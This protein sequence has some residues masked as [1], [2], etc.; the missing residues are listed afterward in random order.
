MAA[1]H[2]PAPSEVLDEHVDQLGH[3]HRGPIITDR[4]PG[5]HHGPVAPVGI[6]SRSSSRR[7]STSAKPDPQSK[8]LV[9]SRRAV[10][11]AAWIRAVPMPRR[12]SDP[13]TSKCSSWETPGRYRRTL[14]AGQAVREEGALTKGFHEHWK[15]GSSA[16]LDLQ[17]RT[18]GAQPDQLVAPVHLVSPR[19]KRRAATTSLAR[20]P[21]PGRRIARTGSRA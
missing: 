18:Y 16:R 15:R 6:P 20:R 4:P 17:L 5:P 2:R 21:R 19:G 12:C 3:G 1:F 11:S 8:P 9:P 10:S 14:G 13:T 7:A